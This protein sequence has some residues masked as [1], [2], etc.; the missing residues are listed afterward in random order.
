MLASLMSK[1]TDELSGYLGSTTGALLSATFGN[2]VEMIITLFALEK[3]LYTVVRASIIGAILT[4]LL[5]TLG[6]C[7]VAGG[8][9]FTVQ[10]FSREKAGLNIVML[11][12]AVIGLSVTGLLYISEPSHVPLYALSLGVSVIFLIVYGLGLVFSLLTHR[13]FVAGLATHSQPPVWSRRKSLILLCIATVCV[14]FTSDLLVNTVAPLAT[15]FGWSQTF[16]GLI[17]LPLVG[18]APECFTAIRLARTGRM[19]GSLEIAVGSSL[20][21]AMF[22]APALVVVGALSGHPL[23][24]QFSVSET[25]TLSLATLLVGFVSLDGKTHWFEGVMVL[26]TYVIFAMMFFYV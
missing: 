3:G 21:I 17:F 6:I 12:V 19:D 2:S 15:S 16:I 9:K 5:L 25:V 22:V 11:F 24:L 1:A 4:N 20:Q 26:A 23:S 10:T 14:A 7:I 8:L 13:S 18:T